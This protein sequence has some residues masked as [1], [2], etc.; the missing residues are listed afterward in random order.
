MSA[1]LLS[2]K[3][4]NHNSHQQKGLEPTNKRH[5][6]SK[7]KEEAKIRREEGHSCCYNI[8]SSTYQVRDHQLEDDCIA[9]VLP[10]E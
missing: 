2:Q 5:S 7:D 3:H 4:Q 1:H 10:Q 8:K 9:E 6:I